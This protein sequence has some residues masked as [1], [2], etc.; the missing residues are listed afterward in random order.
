MVKYIIG[1]L[2]HKYL[3]ENTQELKIIA[4][5]GPGGSVDWRVVLCTKSL[6]VQ[7]LVRAKT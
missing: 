2:G 7:S 5:P 1:K 3:K 4:F 6:Q